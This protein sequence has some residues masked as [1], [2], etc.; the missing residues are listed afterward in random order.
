MREGQ[1]PSGAS[2][3]LHEPERG[4]AANRFPGRRAAEMATTYRGG[5]RDELDRFVGEGLRRA[6][7]QS[8]DA[9]ELWRQLGHAGRGG[10]KLRPALL[11]ASYDCFGGKDMELVCEVGAALELLHTAFVIHDDVIDRDVVR[12]GSSNVSGFFTERARARGAS[13]DGAV[14]L[15][16]AAGVLAGDLALASAIQQ[17]AMCEASQE[18]T[19]Q[20]LALLDDAV[21]VSAAGEL[22]DVVTS[23]CRSTVTMEQVL[24]IAEQKTA[25]YSFRLPLLAGAVLAG[26]P[27]GTVDQLA[28]VG[29]LAGIGFQLVDDLRRL[30]R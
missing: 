21:R 4:E 3:R 22:D 25:W 9:Q 10:K 8:A 28:V 2:G 14:T 27:Q 15:G 30:R 13:E 11:F 23:L 20:L 26:A 16:V 7:G 12:R 5:L 1:L 18:T 17:I 19:R 6:V 24:A 29:R